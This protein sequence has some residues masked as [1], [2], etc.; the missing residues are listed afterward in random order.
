MNFFKRPP[1][2]EAVCIIKHV[3]DTLSGKI[4][5]PPK[6]DYPIHKSLFKMFDKLLK[7]EKK[8]QKILKK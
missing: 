2:D 6:V 8:C 5:E 3:E 1:C 7:S 4:V